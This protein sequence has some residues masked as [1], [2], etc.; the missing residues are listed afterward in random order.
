MLTTLKKFKH[1]VKKGTL[2]AEKKK[3]SK[4]NQVFCEMSYFFHNKQK[5][6]EANKKMSK[7]N[8][9]E[10]RNKRLQTKINQNSLLTPKKFSSSPLD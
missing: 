3:R 6:N 2:T 9:M 10:L 4:L 5:R 1:I 7:Q 8:R